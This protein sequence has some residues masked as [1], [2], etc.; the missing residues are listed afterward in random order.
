MLVYSGQLDAI[1]GAPLTEA[2]LKKL[3]WPGQAAFAKNPRTI[4]RGDKDNA[5]QGYAP[6]V[7]KP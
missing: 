7:P 6:R 3:E 5:V 2:F 4:W 1:I